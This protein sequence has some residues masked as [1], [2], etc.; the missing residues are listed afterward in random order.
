[1]QVAVGR[2]VVAAVVDAP[3]G[4]GVVVG[5][6]LLRDHRR[7]RAGEEAGGPRDVEVPARVLRGV[8]GVGRLPRGGVRRGSIVAE[9]DA[10]RV[11]RDGDGHHAGLDLGGRDLDG[12][13]PRLALVRGDA[14][15]HVRVLAGPDEVRVA[16]GVDGDAG[17][18][19]GRGA[20]HASGL[21]DVLLPRHAR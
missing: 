12:G 5:R 11:A 4:D 1:Q 2:A 20:A 17:I 13:A 7:V 15:V 19:A 10:A 9:H 21:D 3:D 16:C 14:G 18:V 8:V 6:Q